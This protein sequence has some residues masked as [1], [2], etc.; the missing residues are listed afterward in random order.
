MS[1]TLKTTNWKTTDFLSLLRSFSEIP[2]HFYALSEQQ[3]EQGKKFEFIIADIPEKFVTY[4][5]HL[6]F[7]ECFCNKDI[8]NPKI[9]ISQG[10]LLQ[11]EKRI[12]TVRTIIHDFVHRITD[13]SIEALFQELVG[14]LHL[15]NFKNLKAKFSDSH[16]SLYFGATDAREFLSVS[17]E[18]YIQGKEE[19]YKTYGQ[20]MED[21]EVE[22]LYQF[23]TDKIFLA[24]R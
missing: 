21:Q 9:I 22:M 18:Y 24:E 13:I 5:G 7:K 8:Q 16:G 1:T 3:K 14:L 4:G 23:L 19:F 12:Q 10:I 17:A 2:P 6:P 20:F 11:E 15:E